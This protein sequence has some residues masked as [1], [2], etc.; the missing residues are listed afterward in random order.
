MKKCDKLLKE[1]SESIDN[2][3]L[4]VNE[5]NRPFVSQL[6]LE[7]L[8]HFVE[9]VCLKI[10]CEDEGLD[11]DDAYD[12]L[13]VALKHIRKHG[14]YRFIADFHKKHLQKS[15][16]HSIPSVDYSETL[17]LLY[18]TPLLQI[19]NYLYSRFG[20]VV[21]SNV[22]RFPLDLDD[23]FYNY[24]KNIWQ[25]ISSIEFITT[26]ETD[27]FY[28]Y[29][30][31]PI[32]V[33]GHLMYELTLGP[34][35]DY[36]SRFDRMVVFSTIDVFDNYA[37]EAQLR[38]E[39]TLCFDSSVNIC[40]LVDYKVSIRTYELKNLGR[41]FGL[42]ES[43]QRRQKEFSYLMRL[44][45]DNR[46]SL[47]DIVDAE[48]T[49]FASFEAIIKTVAKDETPILNI[50]IRARKIIKNNLPGKNIIR[51]LLAHLKN[52]VVLSQLSRDNNLKASLLCVR[53]GSLN[54]EETPFASH[55]VGSRNP[56]KFVFDC[57]DGDD[58]ECQ[59]LAR[60]I[61][62][63]S[64]KTG[65]LY[66]AASSLYEGDNIQSVIQKYNSMIP[67]FEKD[68]MINSYRDSIFIAANEE[69][70]VRI[71]R[72]VLNHTNNGISGYINLADNWLNGNRSNVLGE[73]KEDIIR[74]MFDKTTVFALY[75]AAGTGKSKTTSF[76]LD[77]FARAK[78]ICLAATYPAVENMR[79]KINDSSVVYMT[80]DSF[81]L[82]S[83]LIQIGTLWSLMSAVLLVTSQ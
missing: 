58:S 50:F 33:E 56:L 64:D 34:A 44:I 81:F 27:F 22:S 61:Q 13:V 20:I 70:T 4:M 83:L 9:H 28:V 59:L 5:E 73:E 18:W 82:K 68:R 72:T 38:Y 15:V 39:K 55:L 35:N 23:T 19:K 10:Y 62:E 17:L 71:L 57:I 49:V 6:V 78:R 48:D 8:R 51:Y 67:D 24:Y 53:N 77:I 69:N 21:L 12:N 32:W 66:V 54:F 52:N 36:A 1:H 7:S 65:Q 25:T 80:I 3:L 16:S 14:Q 41:I 2:K 26:D 29:K 31:K 63:K 46:V 11:L 79:R 40:I 37:I 47:L 76:L 74:N 30:K 43:I 60:R 75:G 45:K 42:S